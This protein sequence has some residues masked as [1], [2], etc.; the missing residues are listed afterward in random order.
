MDSTQASSTSAPQPSQLQ[1]AH[2]AP[3]SPLH[4]LTQAQASVPVASQIAAALDPLPRN[5]KLAS[6][7]SLLQ[8]APTVGERIDELAAEAWNYLINNQLWTHAYPCLERLQDH[9]NY[10]Q[11]LKPILKRNTQT[12]ARKHREIAQITKYWGETPDNVIPKDLLP[13]F[14]STDF[15]RTLTQLSKACSAEAAIPLLVDAI[16]NRL[17]K[18]KTSKDNCLLPGDLRTVLA[19][20]KLLTR[21]AP[22]S[23]TYVQDSEDSATEEGQ[24]T[25]IPVI[26]P[27]SAAEREILDTDAE[28]EEEEE[29]GA[30]KDGEEAEK[31]GEEAEKEAEEAEKEAE[32]A[33]KEAEEAEKEAEEAE[34]EAEEAEKEG[35]E[36]AK[37][38]EK[39]QEKDADQE[40]GTD[41]ED[42]QDQENIPD[43]EDD[44]DQENI[45]DQED[46]PDQEDLS[47]PTNSFTSINLASPPS[48]STST[49]TCSCYPPLQQELDALQGILQDKQGLHLILK[50]YNA[51][52]DKLC[53]LHLRKLVKSSV[54]LKNNYSAPTLRQRLTLVKKH[55]HR[56]A[57]LR[58]GHPD[59]F[60]KAR[61]P[62]DQ[63]RLSGPA[64]SQR[65]LFQY[66][67]T[68]PPLFCIDRRRVLDHFAGRGSWV[69]WTGEGTLIIPNIFDYLNEPDILDMIDQ[70]FDMYQ[71]HSIPNPDRPRMG[72][73]RNMYFSLIQQLVRQDPVWYALCAAVQGSY[74]LVAYPY[75]AK[76][77]SPGEQTGFLHLDINV[78]TYLKSFP[79]SHMSINP[80]CPFPLVSSSLSLDNED[81]TGCTLAVPYFQLHIKAWYNRVLARGEG[82]TGFTTNCST[83]YRKED[84]DKWG[85]PVPVPCPA[86]GLRITRPDIIH[87]STSQASVRRRTLFAWYKVLEEDCQTFK[88]SGSLTWT[89]VSTCHRDLVIPL[90]EPSGQPL[91]H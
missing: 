72:W 69:K 63:S 30:E 65:L 52:L 37:E 56:L 54:G 68:A 25:I 24:D 85:K 59:W 77:A 47:Q 61:R 83:T 49:P 12:Q 41:Q 67:P 8:A 42:D 3:A 50:A 10:N 16:Q 13:P 76:D 87:G 19:H 78:G 86:F 20:L 58:A 82:S 23:S 14:F 6:V 22:L 4:F 39:E 88:G 28:E 38:G 33:E 79:A 26:Q 43:Q 35:Q 71:H 53:H 73:C 29:K 91:K 5:D 64:S 18:P 36:A 11:N 17:A 45:P 66:Q 46:N 44:Q 70:E 57:Q 40:K 74:Q 31:E 89:D 62:T 1:S 32:E 7:I 15:L 34:K 21:D 81:S 51:R 48:T 9:V 80:A 27:A 75:I 2:A 84:R 60:V 90:E 55:G